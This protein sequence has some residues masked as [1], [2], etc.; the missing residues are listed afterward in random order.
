MFDFEQVLHESFDLGRMCS[1]QIGVDERRA[2]GEGDLARVYGVIDTRHL[3]QDTVHLAA[4]SKF[5]VIPKV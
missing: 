4:I 5:I 3:F 2:G 1:P